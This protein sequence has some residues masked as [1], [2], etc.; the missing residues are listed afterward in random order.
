MFQRIQSV[1]LLLTD[2]LLVLLFFVPYGNLGV[3]AAATPVAALDLIWPL[4]AQFVVSSIA[5]VAAI[6]YRNRK[7]QMR[8]C[9]IGAAVSVM[10]L[11]FVY[12][13]AINPALFILAYY[14]IK[15]DDDMVRSADRLR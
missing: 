2:L 8:L 5:V 15:R 10:Y 7:L 3:A 14:F 13:S 6:N 4:V 11:A 9:L 1:F 12:F